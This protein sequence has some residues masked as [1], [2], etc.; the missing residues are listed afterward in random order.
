MIFFFL[1]ASALI[2]GLSLNNS[3]FC[4]SIISSSGFIPANTVELN[5]ETDTATVAASFGRTEVALKFS[6]GNVAGKKVEMTA[7]GYTVPDT[8][9]SGPK[10]TTSFGYYNI[11]SKDIS[12]SFSA[13]LK[14]KYSDEDFAAAG[15]SESDITIAYFNKNISKWEVM[16]TQID[17]INNIA[18]AEVNHFSLW[19]LT[20]KN[21]ELIT[22]VEEEIEES[23]VPS[24]YGISQNY[25]NPFNPT[26]TIEYS[27]PKT[28]FINILVYNI[29]GQKVATLVD[30][31][32][33]VGNYKI[34][35]NAQGLA[36]GIYVYR[37]KSDS[38]VMTKKMI[39]IK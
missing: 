28:G 4:S 27:V 3:N 34:Q 25:P 30:E 22:G 31:V 29:L 26:T 5:V 14:F 36:S 21:E 11:E 19:A 10:F 24:D 20:S 18:S 37:L 6:S 8:V 9:H 13:T 2:S 7:Y 23:I 15:I 39:L 12:T 17:P 38:K 1:S 32:K 33:S 35:W 16:T